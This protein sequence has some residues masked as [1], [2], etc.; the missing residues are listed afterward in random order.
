LH[1]QVEFCNPWWNTVACIWLN[2]DLISTISR[3]YLQQLLKS[4]IHKV[5]F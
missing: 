1:L 2:L 3:W 4:C 5:R